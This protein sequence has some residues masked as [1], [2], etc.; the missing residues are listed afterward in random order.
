MDLVSVIDKI[1]KLQSLASNNPNINESFAAT[2]AADKLISEYRISAATLEA[3]GATKAE[4]YVRKPVHI[5]GKRSSW[6]ERLVSALCTEYGAAWYIMHPDNEV[7]YIV[8]AKESD[9]AIISYMFSFCTEE[10]EKLCRM[11]GKGQGVGWSKSYLEG[12]SVGLA[13]QLKEARLN[14][15]S[16]QETANALLRAIGQDN[17]SSAAMVIL[18]TRGQEANTFMRQAVGRMGKA[19][20]VRGST[21]NMSGYNN[22]V[23]AGRSV[24]IRKGMGSGNKGMLGG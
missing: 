7:A 17:P 22:G 24:S 12:Y 19:G 21:S 15:K 8:C 10:G 18:D 2:K 20:S 16:K 4:N 9:A 13:A 23:S 5:A 1:K 11:N 6:R 3:A 14:E